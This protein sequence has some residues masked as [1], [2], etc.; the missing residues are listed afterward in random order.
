MKK[1]LPNLTK[2]NLRK[3]FKKTIGNHGLFLIIL[4]FAFGLRCYRLP[5]MAYFDFDQ[6]YASN[7]A[8]SVLREFPIQMIGQGLSIQ[9]LFMG[10]LYFYYLVPFFALFNLH[11]IGG[12]VGSAILGLVIITA[13]YYYGNKLFGKSAGLIAAFLRAFL[14]FK[15]E[16]DWSMVPSYSSELLVLVT[17]YCFYQYWQGNTKHLPLLG[18][19]FGLYTSF[20]P[21]LFPFYLV[22]LILLIIRRVRPNLRVL[23]LSIGAFIVPITPLLLFEYFHEFL[24]VKRL[25]ELFSNSRPE[26][27]TLS[28]A[29]L[30]TY[31][32]TIMAGLQPL[33]GLNINPPFLLSGMVLIAMLIFTLRRIHVWQASF[34]LLT[35]GI[36]FLVFVLYYYFLPVHVSEYYFLAP[37]SLLFFYLSGILGY[38]AFKPIIK[39]AVIVFL[40][41]VVFANIKLLDQKKWSNPSLTT[42]AH[43]DRIV[44]AIVE[45]QSK[46][47][48]FFVSYISL[49]GWDFGFKYL[50]KLYDRKPYDS[51]ME[52]ATYTIVI[53]KSL[54]L[55][56]IDISSGNVGLIL[57]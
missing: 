55:E 17:W 56:S 28:T 44:K 21:I 19:V 40:T 43:K 26:S 16:A 47:R 7:F 48:E 41:Y 45:R 31:M 39:L 4:V 12:A 51:P 1:F 11:P 37:V 8:Y 34:H 18:L 15:L 14:F 50:F 33:L 13:Y 30:V 32:D 42:L 6:E 52:S 29:K 2:V 57:P 20:H 23:L 54:S 3:F 49:L 53:P 10:P 9:G 27:I 46:G 25:I 36:T 5:E 35:L 22:F 38:L 24:E